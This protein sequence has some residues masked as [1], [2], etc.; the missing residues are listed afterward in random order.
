MEEARKKA[1]EQYTKFGGMY[2]N[3]PKEVSVFSP[4]LIK[5]DHT[6]TEKK[7]GDV[8]ARFFPQQKNGKPAVLAQFKNNH[9]SKSIVVKV[10]MLDDGKNILNEKKEVLKKGAS[11]TQTYGI[12][13]YYEV[14]VSDAFEENEADSD[15]FIETIKKWI[16][17]WLI[18]KE[19]IENPTASSGVRG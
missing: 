11:I 13:D 12:A 7:L 18:K 8:D 4:D 10:L 16:Y 15:D 17:Q 1:Q 6:K 5:A 2:A 19:D 3:P 9:K 14:Q